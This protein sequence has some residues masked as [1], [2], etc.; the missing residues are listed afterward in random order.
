MAAG[1]MKV[2]GAGVTKA[3]GEMEAAAKWVQRVE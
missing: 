2:A 1:G 3:E